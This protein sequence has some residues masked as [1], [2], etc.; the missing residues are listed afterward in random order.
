MSKIKVAIADDH[1][2]F[3]QGLSIMFGADP[4]IEVVIEA[5]DGEELLSKLTSQNC[6]VL[7]LDIEMPKLDGF[8]VLDE[9]RKRKL[10]LNVL[11]ISMYHHYPF[12]SK[13]MKGGANG[14]LPKNCDFELAR[15]AIRAV[16]KGGYFFDK[17]TSQVILGI[18]NDEL[19][20]QDGLSDKEC[21]VIRM[22]CDGKKNNEIAEELF[23]SSRT[24][25]GYRQSIYKKTGTENVPELVIYA[26]RY[27]IIQL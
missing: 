16:H 20:R 6:D 21:D 25:E 9:I 27:G 10:K 3:R 26:V 8:A 11:I 4:E 19:E 1:D 18:E 13:A 23:V 7:V 5:A 22:I 24:V 12:I 15:E 2:L 14:F 17:K